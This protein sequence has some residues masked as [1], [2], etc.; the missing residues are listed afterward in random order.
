MA[1]LWLADSSKYRVEPR[2]SS[3]RCALELGATAAMVGDGL[4]NSRATSAFR[5][6]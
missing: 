1:L 6:P 5:S 4:A 2:R 3:E